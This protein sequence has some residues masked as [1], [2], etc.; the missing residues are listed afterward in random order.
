MKKFL[1]L[2]C[3][4]GIFTLSSAQN[5]QS[6]RSDRVSFYKNDG[7]YAM[8]AIKI[9]SVEMIG[10]DSVLHLFPTIRI[11]SYDCYDAFGAPWFGKSVTIKPDGTN[12][13]LNKLNLPVTIH[14]QYPVGM[15]WVCHTESNGNYV[16][17]YVESVE[18]I[19]FLTV[20]DTVKTIVFYY[21]NANNQ[22][23]NEG[24][25]N[26]RIKLSKNFG[27]IQALPFYVFPNI[28]YSYDNYDSEP[29]VEYVLTG[30]D[31]EIGDSNIGYQD[32]FDFQP[33]D[34]IHTYYESYHR[35]SPSM[36]YHQIRR[37]IRI[38]IERTD[39]AED[40]V[41]YIISRCEVFY[42][43]TPSQT[44]VETFNDTI[45]QIYR[46]NNVGVNSKFLQLPQETYIPYSGMAAYLWMS[47]KYN[48]KL[49]KQFMD[50]ME[51]P[52]HYDDCY[53]YPI[54]D[55]C[56]VRNTYA[57][58]LGGP[59]YQCSFHS[60]YLKSHLIYYKKGDETWGTPYVC[61]W[62]LGSEDITETS[63]Q[64]LKIFPN[65]A[66]NLVYLTLPEFPASIKI[67]D[68]SGKLRISSEARNHE[69]VLNVSAL[70]AGIYMLQVQS[71]N[72]PPTTIK[73]FKL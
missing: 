41:E 7:I 12:V 30:I 55:G 62:L 27:M 8:R 10:N 70:S 45:I 49:C 15:I 68:L 36:F 50:G 9:D 72:D 3:L 18:V 69:H 53:V 59:Y 42:N 56:L 23:I 33:E 2:C 19:D 25:H 31:N 14:T 37:D 29:V 32:V 43:K 17:A 52:M 35:A 44:I 51:M 38:I 11:I 57:K 48:D 58:G 34:E 22:I 40:S 63:K 26:K 39:F 5:Y 66:E 65:P 6:V 28:D 24:V 46:F 60:D 20:T 13:F 16:K 1:L 61:D 21:Y 71:H 73:F 64:E 47:K 4:S 54:F 67:F